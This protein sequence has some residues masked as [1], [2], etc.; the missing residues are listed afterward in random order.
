MKNQ[1]HANFVIRSSL[2]LALALAVWAPVRSQA[3]EPAQGE[4]MMGGKMM[5]HGQEMMAQRQNMM[6]EMKA[7]DA[8]LTAMVAQM[9]S[10][11]EDKKVDLIAA[12]VTRLVEQRTAMNERMEKMH[13]E[14]MQRMQ[15]GKDSMSQSPTMKGMEGQT[16]DTQKE[17]K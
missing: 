16:G 5:E 10:A 12:I 7:Q 9:N 13:T 11:P 1:T 8:E 15:K 4:R 17:Q 2:V 6:A 3:A 14:M